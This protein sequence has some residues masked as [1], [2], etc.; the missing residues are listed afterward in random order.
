MLHQYCHVALRNPLETQLYVKGISVRILYNNVKVGEISLPELTEEQAIVLPPSDTFVTPIKFPVELF[1]VDIKD[2][3]SLLRELT[4]HPIGAGYAKVDLDAR[5]KARA[6]PH[7][8][9]SY[10]VCHPPT[11]VRVGGIEPLL[12][13]RQVLLNSA[14]QDLQ[15]PQAATHPPTVERH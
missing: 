15:T 13:Y 9:L 2:L 6:P 5:I 12:A 3:L 10:H 11:K 8:R 4:P 1:A 7:T 14:I